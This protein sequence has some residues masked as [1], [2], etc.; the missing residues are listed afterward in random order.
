MTILQ[1][2]IPKQIILYGGTGQAKVVKPIIEYYG[3]KVIAVFD[4]KKN[5]YPPF[6]SIDL[7][8]G[9]QSLLKWKEDVNIN[10]IG[11]VKEAPILCCKSI[12]TGFNVEDI[13]M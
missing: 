2:D 3:S 7:F 12:S 5:L 13:N 10:E 4:D 11:K 1:K 6:K 9:Y 8:T